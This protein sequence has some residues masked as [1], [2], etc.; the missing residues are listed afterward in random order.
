MNQM[1]QVCN[2]DVIEDELHTSEIS[3]LFCIKRGAFSIVFKV[4]IKEKKKKKVIL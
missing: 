2:S 4:Y 3:V 1:I